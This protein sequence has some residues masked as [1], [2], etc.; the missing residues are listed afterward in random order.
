MN[1][2]GAADT[3]ILE[4]RG[5]YRRIY[6]VPGQAIAFDNGN[7]AVETFLGQRYVTLTPFWLRF[8]AATFTHSLA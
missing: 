8:L 1:R 2:G 4:R 6:A 3:L 7:W 5:H